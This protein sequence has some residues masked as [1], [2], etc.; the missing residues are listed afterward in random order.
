MVGG[1]KPKSQRAALKPAD[2][3]RA[4]RRRSGRVPR[5]HLTDDSPVLHDLGGRRVISLGPFVVDGG[6][7][8][9]ALARAVG[10]VVASLPDVVL[11]EIAKGRA[12]A[13]GDQPL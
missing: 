13:E 12:T 8:A 2:K 11:L 3:A 9:Q 7:P 10:D 5:D 4:L 6:A 1:A